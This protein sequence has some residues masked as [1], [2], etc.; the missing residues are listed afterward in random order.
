M[1]I[2]PADPRRLSQV[3]ALMPL[4]MAEAYGAAWHGSEEALRAAAAEGAL[5]I[6]VAANGAETVAGFIAW[7]PAYDLHWCVAGGAVLDLY[8]R[9]EARGRAV[10]IRLLAAAAARLR[11]DGGAFLR[12][13]AL[14]TGP[15]KELY[16]R[17][18]VCNPATECTLSGRAFRELAEL[19]RLPARELVRRLPNAA[20]NYEA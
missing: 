3:A 8:V 11:L 15:G 14:D 19:E 10:A 4:Y 2:E 17:A 12:G 1:T 6:L 18:A 20:W 7:T 16:S 9:P 13:T 5:R